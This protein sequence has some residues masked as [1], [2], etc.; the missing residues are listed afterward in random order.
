[1]FMVHLYC[2]EKLPKP[3]WGQMQSVNLFSLAIVK[4][5]GPILK[6]VHLGFGLNGPHCTHSLGDL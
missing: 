4:F 1:M 3:P 5:S 6:R 2:S